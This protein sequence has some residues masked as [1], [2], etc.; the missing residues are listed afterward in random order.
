MA[1]TLTDL[2]NIE[3]AIATGELSC[4]LEGKSVT[5]RSI[6]ELQAARDMIRSDLQ[7]AGSLASSSFR[8]SYASRVR[9]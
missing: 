8:A 7:A 3:A 2:Q 5:Y 4:T 1:F 9:V 6:R